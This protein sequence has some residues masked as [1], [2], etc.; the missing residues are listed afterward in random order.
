MLADNNLVRRLA[1]CEIMGGATTICSD[2][3]GTLTQNK[4]LS[5]YSLLFVLYHCRMKCVSGFLNNQ[6]LSNLQ[7]VADSQTPSL[8]G[9]PKVL[10][11]LLRVDVVYFYFV[12]LRG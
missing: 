5:F 9:L 12:E 6:I 3:T 7:K 4:F 8:S 11:L 10:L 2:K 1:S